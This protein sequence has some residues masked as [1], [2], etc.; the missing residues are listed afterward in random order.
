M[1]AT[2]R[3]SVQVRTPGN[4]PEAASDHCSR[5]SPAPTAVVV[6]LLPL[7][8]GKEA[9]GG[10]RGARVA[11]SGEPDL[12]RDLREGDLVVL[13]KRRA[14]R[15]PPFSQGSGPGSEDCREPLTPI[16]NCR[17]GHLRRA[18]LEW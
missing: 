2:R 9:Y 18:T 5:S 17:A 13:F 11:R 16:A 1:T 15:G 14:R 7:K 10:G 6:F 4:R 8:C 3:T 12:R